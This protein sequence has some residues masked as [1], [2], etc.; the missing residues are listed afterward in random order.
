MK[1]EIIEL[2]KIGIGAGPAFSIR[3]NGKFLMTP[4]GRRRSWPTFAAAYKAAGGD[5]GDALGFNRSA[6]DCFATGVA[7]LSSRPWRESQPGR[8]TGQIDSAPALAALSPGARAVIKACSIQ[9]DNLTPPDRSPVKHFQ[10]HF[11]VTCTAEEY[12][13]LKRQFPLVEE[14]RRQASGRE[15]LFLM[16]WEHG[17][18]HPYQFLYLYR[19]SFG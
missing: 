9:R 4:G 6:Q 16:K 19:A 17:K 2:K 15:Q 14:T 11:E 7:V 1:L 3:E 12:L 10:N 8:L 5:A 18:S 13:W